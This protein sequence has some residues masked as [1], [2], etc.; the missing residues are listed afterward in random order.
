MRWLHR[1]LIAT[2]TLAVAG[3]VVGR[4]AT[5]R[6]IVADVRAAMASGGVAQ[7]EKILS[8]YRSTH[9]SNPD[10][11]EALSWVAR[12]ALAAKQY[13]KA[14]QLAGETLDLTVAA[15]KTTDL[16]IEPRLQI[17]LS[18]AL[19]TLAFVL[20]DQGAR[21]DAVYL[22][23]NQLETY[24]DSPIREQIQ[25]NIDLVTLE[26]KPAPPLASGTG[27]GAHL[28]VKD[29]TGHPTLLFFWAHWCQECKAESPILSRLVEKYRPQGLTV[30]APTRRYGYV[31]GGRPATPDR[32]LRYIVQVR[33][34]FYRF[35]QHA[36]VP[37][38]DT[39]HRLYGVSAVPMHVLI[40]RQGVVRL[41]RPGLM[42]ETELEAAIAKALR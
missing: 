20:V 4:A 18:A 5:D 31:E 8:A 27:L 17:A 24:R 12:G 25:S 11:I 15:L 39:N 42:T 35:L 10:A 19:E 22:L 30:V 41:Y 34:T 2:A 14:D 37:V 38:T 28:P 13:R 16:R 21:S 1:V 32:E 23:R 6:D 7:A 29:S 9:P 40:D 3:S 26:G 36:P 33:D